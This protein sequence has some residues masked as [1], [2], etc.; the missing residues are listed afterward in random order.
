[1]RVEFCLLDTDY[2]LEDG[3]PV[4]RLWGKTKNGR[5][6]LALDRDFEPYFY[7][8]LEEEY[9][10]GRKLDDFKQRLRELKEFGEKIK[11]IEIVERKYLGEP[12]KFLKV[13]VFNPREISDIREIIKEWKGLKNVYEYDIS[14]YRRYLIDKGLTPMGWVS[15][16]GEEKR[17]ETTVD[18]TLEIVKVTPVEGRQ[19]KL[20][21]MAVDIE[22]CEDEI[23]MISVVAKGF[24]KVLTYGWK[25][26]GRNYV[27]VLRDEGEMIKR[28][29]EIVKEKDPDIIVT[30]N[31]DMFDFVKL[32]ERAEHHK[33]LLTLGRDSGNLVFT[34]RGR[35]SSAK[36]TGRIHVDLYN[37]IFHILGSSLSSETLT[38]D[39]VSN[40]LLGMGK[41]PLEW[42]EIEKL[43]KERKGLDK[44]AKY[45]EWDSKLT[46][47]LSERLLFRFLNSAE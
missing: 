17:S 37:F 19:P 13:V 8:E 22:M 7:I 30:Y 33:I 43:W 16:E 38:L 2:V 15:A 46:L 25:E 41:K 35:I 23:I 14:F 42:R 34:R 39:M 28:F 47:K 40:E 44:I 31:G 26:K 45:C 1:M 27:E 4:V 5:S 12:K 11:R 24:R 29:I 21:V 3:R 6:I 9:L 10:R 18:K 20:R 32:R 36:I